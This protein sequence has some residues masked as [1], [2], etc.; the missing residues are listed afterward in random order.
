MSREK[1][2]I[3]IVLV[4]M[5][6]FF[7]IRILNN[8]K[9]EN[10]KH[11]LEIASED[12]K[13][14]FLDYKIVALSEV[15]SLVKNSFN[16]LYNYSSSIVS[17]DTSFNFLYISSKVTFPIP[18]IR[19]ID[20]L[21]EKCES[22]INNQI[23]QEK[24]STNKRKLRAKYPNSFDKWFPN[25][26]NELLNK[27]SNTESCKVFFQDKYLLFIQSDW[28]D[29]KK[30]LVFH[31]K[32]LLSHKK[33]NNYVISK[34]NAL[35]KQKKRN[36]KS[37][38]HSKFDLKMGTNKGN[39]IIKKS[40]LKS[41]NSKLTG[42][43]SFEIDV[44]EFNENNF[45][46]ISNKVFADQWKTNSL[47]TGSMPY[48]SCFGSTNYGRSQINIKNSGQ[49]VV[50]LV[51]DYID[52]VIR[53]A[54]I[55]GNDY[56]EIKIPDGRYTVFFYNG[57]G[58]NPIKKMKETYCGIPMGGFVSRESFTKDESFYI[59]NQILTYTLERSSYGNF[60]PKGSS[61]NEAF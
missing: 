37:K 16:K 14:D 41:Y 58:W 19:Y 3:L 20:C 54:Y 59:T 38:Y 52:R 9:I 15:D 26:E 53:H 31:N 45:N 2:I 1:K 30:L 5:F 42:K 22:K 11:N 32:E 4:L 18:D 24:I 7:L 48:A 61:M 21:V 13:K 50:I 36:L 35:K 29:F 39:I 33:K 56:F 27:K 43:L 12:L 44:L 8:F 57:K 60:N 46:D 49:D 10:F 6:P 23:N 51:K 28:N 40:I 17:F 47:R 55:K 34:F 25:Y